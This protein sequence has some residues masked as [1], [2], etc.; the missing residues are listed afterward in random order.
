MEHQIT[1][2]A[3]LG[4][5]AT[6]TVEALL[7]YRTLVTSGVTPVGTMSDLPTLLFCT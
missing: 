4:A 7:L 1:G 2:T 3:W 6:V 5:A